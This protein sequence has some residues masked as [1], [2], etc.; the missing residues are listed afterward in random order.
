M[1]AVARIRSLADA[2]RAVIL[3]HNYQRAEVQDLADFVG[4]SLGLSRQAAATDAE[5]VVFCGVDFMA[6][7]AKILSPS[8]TVLLPE[9]DAGCPMAQMI[10]PEGLRALKAEHPGIPVVCYVNSSAAVKAES[11]ICCTSANASPVVL[12]L[13]AD[14]VIF[15]PDR[16]LG[17]WVAR[18]TGVEV[19]P[20]PGYCPTHDRI[21]AEDVRAL[22]ARH[23]DAGFMCHPECRPD[24]T[25]LAHAV[26]STS[27]MIEWAKTAPF[28]VII[29][30]TEAGLLHRL[31]KDSPDKEFILASP[32]AVCPNM[33][34]TRLESV[35]D[36]L[37]YCQYEVTVPEDIRVRALAAVERMVAIG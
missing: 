12:S 6:E 31:S 8:K 32:R 37:E 22:M 30:G 21:M 4:D 11:D 16:N 29:V 35:A 33:K 27:Q 7:T 26:L 5:M 2:K 20:W 24:V 36:A 18:Q 19:I 28:T 25:D 14:E 13:D 9:Q 34:L 23:P 10:T 17:S 3:A 15:V 1:D